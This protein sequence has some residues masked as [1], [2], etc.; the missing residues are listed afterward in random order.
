MSTIYFIADTHFY[1]TN[2]INYCERPF[3]T[4]DEMNNVLIQNWNATVGYEDEIYI[5][6]DFA[7]EKADRVHSLV[8][9]LAGKKYL[10]RGNHDKFL[11][12]YELYERDFIWIKDYAEISAC[13]RKFVLFHYPITEWAGYYRE[14]VHCYGHVHN[15]AVAQGTVDQLGKMG[16]KPYKL[17]GRAVN[18]G[19]DVTGFRPIGVHEV[20][21]IADSKALK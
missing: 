1:H 8:T 11:N 7:F 6:G 12:N 5:L 20:I 15:G 13:G 21:R 18:V 17:P 4:V 19:V 3:A 14:A 2:I 10:L 9:R 16:K